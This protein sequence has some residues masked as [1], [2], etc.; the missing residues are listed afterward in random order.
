MSVR[1]YK[2]I[3]VEYKKEPTFN[4]WHDEEIMDSAILDNY[5]GESG[6]ITIERKHAEE[7]LKEAKKREKSEERDNLIDT[8]KQIIKD[9]EGDDYVEYYC[10]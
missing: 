3:K 1:A 8:L 10:F 9:C 6:D 7:L 2:K 5:T 4:C